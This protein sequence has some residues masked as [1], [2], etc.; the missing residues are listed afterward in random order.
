MNRAKKEKKESVI[1]IT[2]IMG[3][4]V[5][6]IIFIV[7]LNVEKNTIANYERSEAVVAKKD[8]PYGLIIDEKNVNDYFQIKEYE[9]DMLPSGVCVDAKS[10][11]GMVM[12]SDVNKDS[13]ITSSMYQELT[14]TVIKAHNMVKASFEAEK[15]SQV[16]N[17]TLRP[18]DKITIA[19]YEE[20]DKLYGI[21]DKYTTKNVWDDVFVYEVFDSTGVK[22]PVDD[23]KT[24]AQL[25]TVLINKEDMQEFYLG[26]N[27]S[28]LQ[29]IKLVRAE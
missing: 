19:V 26:L 7:L 8:I 14:D 29:V 11:V 20:G 1:F 22:I 4:I 15:L 17:G 27:T 2:L 23:D 25:I 3:F 21:E 16:V 9:K 18:G 28:T 10:L 5:A 12:A 24:A 6:A 13:I